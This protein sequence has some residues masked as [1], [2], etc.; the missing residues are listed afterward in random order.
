MSDVQLAWAGGL[1][2]QALLLPR[3]QNKIHNETL[4]ALVRTPEG[5]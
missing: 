2:R 1:R 5:D 4:A 3:P